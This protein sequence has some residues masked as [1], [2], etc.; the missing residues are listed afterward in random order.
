M[1]P[2]DYELAYGTAI[3]VET[4]RPRLTNNRGGL[5]GRAIKPLAL[6]MVN[7][8]HQKCKLSDYWYRRRGDGRG[9]SG[10]SCRLQRRVQVGT[11]L[12]VDPDAPVKIAEGLKQYMKR[13]KLAT[14]RRYGRQSEEMVMSAL[15]NL[16]K[17][18]QKNRSM[19]CLGSISIRRR[20]RRSSRGRSRDVS[21]LRTG[22]SMRLHRIL[23]ALTKP[24]LAF[25]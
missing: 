5:T 23:S 22:L 18:Q 6:A 11:A 2:G 21:T 17:I 15:N 3:D 13:K 24:N 20:C 4:W 9:R 12:F 16:Q 19:I 8:V 25:L 1:R 10:S 7:A 14:H